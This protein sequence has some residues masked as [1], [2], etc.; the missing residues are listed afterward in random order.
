MSIK[1]EFQG[2]F[3][4][5]NLGPELNQKLNHSG[6]YIWGFMVDDQFNPI[7]FDEQA[8][9][10]PKKMLFLPYY[11]GKK[12]GNILSRLKDHHGVR[13]NASAKKYMR[14]SAKYIKTFFND[15]EFPVKKNYKTD[16][17]PQ[18]VRIDQNSNGANISYYNHADFLLYKLNVHGKNKLNKDDKKNNPITNFNELQDPLDEWVNQKNNFWFCFGIVDQEMNQFEKYL[19]YLETLTFYA[20]KGKTISKTGYFDRLPEDI[21]LVDLTLTEIFKEKTCSK[22]I[23]SNKYFAEGEILFPGY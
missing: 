10:N 15:V 21:L 13:K 17:T 23:L 16:L 7:H 20:L 4:F 22:D 19:E 18:F 8:V 1:I 5:S 6:I 3:H 11:V 14:I 9:Y 2:P 12:K